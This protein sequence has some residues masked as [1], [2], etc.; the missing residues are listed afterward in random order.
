[1]TCPPAAR[2][3]ARTPLLTDLLCLLSIIRQNV[4]GAL[5]Q[6]V[7]EEEPPERV[8]NAP[9]HLNQVLQNVLTGLGEGAHVHHPHGDQQ[10]SVDRQKEEEEWGGVKPLLWSSGMEGLKETGGATH[11]LGMM[12]PAYWT[13]S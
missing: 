5:Q 10:I 8:L 11:N 4:A 1:M 13:S 3:R 6:V 9:A 12:F 7:S 2:A